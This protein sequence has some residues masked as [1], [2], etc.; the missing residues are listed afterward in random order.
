VKGFTQR[1]VRAK[2][3]VVAD[4]LRREFYEPILHS[5]G[6]LRG[7][8]R[9]VKLLNLIGDAAVFSGDVALLIKL[10]T[11][12]RRICT[13]YQRTLAGVDP[14]AAAGEVE[15]ERREM[16]SRLAAI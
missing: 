12:I 10:A 15:R 8:G 7:E 3:I 13:T 4:F 2:E 1:T 9:E 16:Q 6:A 11:D 14:G 5:A